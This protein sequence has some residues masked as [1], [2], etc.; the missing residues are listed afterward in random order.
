MNKKKIHIN[1]YNYT[2]IYIS[3]YNSNEDYLLLLISFMKTQFSN[4][5]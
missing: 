4:D 1:I 5:L 2:F 3:I